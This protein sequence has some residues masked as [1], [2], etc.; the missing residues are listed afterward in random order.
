MIGI[1][2]NS[3]V[4]DN[5]IGFGGIRIGLGGIDVVQGSKKSLLRI[6]N[7]GKIIFS[8]IAQFSEGISIR[9]GPNGR[10]DIGNNF[11]TN[12]KCSLLC[13][14]NMKIGNNVLLG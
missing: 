6:D 11:A 14:G 9:I 3:I 7:G 4:V 13:D 5:S 2:K 8:G 12:K 1:K 10:L